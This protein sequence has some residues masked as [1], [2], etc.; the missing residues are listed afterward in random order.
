MAMA[1]RDPVAVARSGCGGCFAAVVKTGNWEMLH[2]L[3]ALGVRVPDVV[4]GC[5]TYLWHIPEMARV[6]LEHGMDPNLPDWQRATPLHNICNRDGRSRP[7]PNRLQLVDLFLEF[8]ADLN[9]IDEEYRSTPLG[10]AARNGLPDMVKRLLERG[11]DKDVAGAPWA[12]PRA[13]AEKR[14]YQEIVEILMK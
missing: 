6:L 3:L 7:D 2:A 12:T 14:G 8:G 11:G 1:K 13:W 5:R 4:T 9:P 10:W